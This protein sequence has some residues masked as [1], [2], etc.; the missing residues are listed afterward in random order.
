MRGEFYVGFYPTEGWKPGDIPLRIGEPFMADSV[1]DARRKGC[2]ALSEAVKGHSDFAVGIL[3]HVE[4]DSITTCGVLTADGLW[5]KYTSVSDGG[6][7]LHPNVSDDRWEW[8][9]I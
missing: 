7:P 3:C 1:A 9:R 6:R 5:S 2:D 4:K 8:R